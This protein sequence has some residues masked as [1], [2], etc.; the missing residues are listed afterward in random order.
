VAA[1][2]L[3]PRLTDIIEAIERI[4]SV[5]GDMP[6]DVFETDWQRQ[7]LIETTGNSCC[8]SP[9][10]CAAACPRIRITSRLHSGVHSDAA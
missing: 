6:L 9:A 8:G 3:I 4:H 1:R 5:L 7:W 10:S 2:S